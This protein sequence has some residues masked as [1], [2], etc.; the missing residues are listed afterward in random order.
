MFRKKTSFPGPETVFTPSGLA[1]R[2]YAVPC[3]KLAGRRI[4]F[5]SDLHYKGEYT[6]NIF[7]GSSRG[8]DDAGE[9]IFHALGEACEYLRPDD[10]LFG[11]DLISYSCMLPRTAKLLRIFPKGKGKAAVYGNWDKRRR[12]WLPFKAIESLYQ[13]AG[14]T[15]LCNESI[16]VDGLF[17]Y[18]L[19]DYKMGFPRIN[20]AGK[21]EED[22][23]YRILLSHN[24]DAIPNIPRTTLSRFNLALCGHTHAGQIRIPFF[25]AIRTSSD[26]WKKFEYG[27]YCCPKGKLNMIVSAGIGTTLIPI[28]VFCPPE[29]LSIQF[30][31]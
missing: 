9:W 26:Y 23:S 24:P 4:F 6:R 31:D 20:P 25:G 15:V 21:Q 19:D 13:D 7:G 11:G 10:F 3:K 5:F 1:I 27:G 14:W 16:S 30:I 17:L 22:A 12:R 8:W 2:K 29:V 18:G 28:R